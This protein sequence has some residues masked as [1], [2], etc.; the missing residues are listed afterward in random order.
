MGL[1]IRIAPAAPSSQRG[2]IRQKQ[3]QNGYDAVG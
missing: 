2:Q 1:G 3:N